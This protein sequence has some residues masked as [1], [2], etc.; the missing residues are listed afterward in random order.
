MTLWPLLQY[1]MKQTIFNSFFYE[2]SF[3]LILVLTDSQTSDGLVVQPRKKG[4]LLST[5][6]TVVE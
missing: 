3:F 2:P 5:T 1:C 6:S 4:K